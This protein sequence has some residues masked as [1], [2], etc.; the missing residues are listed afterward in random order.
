MSA[1]KKTY[2]VFRSILFTA[3][4]AAG[5]LY[6]ALYVLLS[7][8]GIQNSIRSRAEQELSKLFNVNI[9]TPEG[10]KCIS[11]ETIGA[12]IHLWHLIKDRKIEITYAQILG[13][14]GKICQKKEGDKLNIQFIIDAF[15]P[16][17]KNKPPTTI[18]P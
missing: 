15:A 2:K 7:I 5:V 9:Y 14:N 16:K 3:I 18:S 12:G 6:L 1:I 8:P 13:L 10:A 17:D 4:V 11:V